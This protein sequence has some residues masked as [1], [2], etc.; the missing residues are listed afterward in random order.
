MNKN[1]AISMMAGTI[2]G[3]LG[4]AG[5]MG[6][7]GSRSYGIT[8]VAILAFVSALITRIL[9]DLADKQEGK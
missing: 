4:G 2:V 9:L 6:L 8:T 1:F 7:T 3:M 5:V